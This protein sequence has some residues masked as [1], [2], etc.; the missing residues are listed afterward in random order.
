MFYIA[1]RPYDLRS[2]NLIT[3][4]LHI[5]IRYIFATWWGC[6]QVNGFLDLIHWDPMT[7]YDVMNLCRLWFR[8][9]P[10]AC[11]A[12]SHNFN[13]C[14]LVNWTPSNK[15]QWKLLN[16]TYIH[17]E[18][19]TKN[20]LKNFVAGIYPEKWAYF[21][22]HALLRCMRMHNWCSNLLSSF[23][24]RSV[25]SLYLCACPLNDSTKWLQ[26]ARLSCHSFGNYMKRQILNSSV[27]K[28]RGT[29]SIISELVPFFAYNFEQHLITI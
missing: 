18:S 6:Y 12:P 10:V 17:L 3:E 7:L 29:Q 28:F 22:A 23:F 4:K 21:V 24:N 8:Q 1:Y 26:E 2:R 25:S 5:D 19:R 16:R 13:Q 15:L 27:E 11:S 20:L 14:W 9:M